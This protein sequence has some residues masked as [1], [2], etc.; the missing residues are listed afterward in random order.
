VIVCRASAGGTACAVSVE[1][2]ERTTPAFSRFMFLPLK[3]LGLALNSDTSI[4]SS[5][6]PGRWVR[7]AF[8]SVRPS[9]R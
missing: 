5:E 1:G 6:T 8:F 4:W 7:V 2:T 3:A 9:G